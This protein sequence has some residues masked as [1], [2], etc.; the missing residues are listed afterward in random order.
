MYKK[1]EKTCEKLSLENKKLNLRLIENEN[2]KNIQNESNK[3][4]NDLQNKLKET[5]EECKI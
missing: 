2:N 4:E 5:Q 1:I 3:K